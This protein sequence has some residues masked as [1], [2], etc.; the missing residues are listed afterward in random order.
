LLIRTSLRPYR[1]RAGL[2]LVITFGWSFAL[3]GQAPAQGGAAGGHEEQVMIDPSLHRFPGVVTALG[4]PDQEGRIYTFAIAPLGS[5]SVRPVP[6]QFRGW[7]LTVLTGKLFS[8]TFEI[9]DNSDAQVQVVTSK[10]PING[11][12]A[13]DV[14]IIESIDHAGRSMFAPAAGS[15]GTVSGR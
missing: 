4:E 13:Q 15:Q 3:A 12:D 14:F 9:A 2:V 11:V 10:E 7:R 8:H 1:P 6:G 5:A